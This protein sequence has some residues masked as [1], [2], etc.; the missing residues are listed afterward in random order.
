M[1]AAQNLGE[2]L[3]GITGQITG[4]LASLSTMIGAQGISSAVPTFE[5]RPDMFKNWI[6]N[7]E[8]YAILTNADDNQHKLIAYQSSAGTVSDF[9]Q[10][11]M[12]DHAQATWGDLKTDLAQRFAEV[13]D[14]QHA[15]M[16][17]QKLKQNPGESVQI[18]A[19]RLLN[20]AED[21]YVG[22]GVNRNFPA[23]ERQ[24]VGFFID[25]LAY[26]YLK[27]RIMRENPQTL[28]N[29]VTSATNEQNLRARFDL[30]MG[31]Q[32]SYRRREQNTRV[33]REFVS[34]NREKWSNDS[35]WEEDMDVSH[36]RPKRCYKCNR[37]G[38]QAR[39]C[40]IINAVAHMQTDRQT[41]PRQVICW[42]CN[43]SGHIKRECPKRCRPRFDSP[44]PQR[45]VTLSRS[46][47]ENSLN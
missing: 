8:K 28:A 10:R 40:K 33:R 19:E 5:G 17:L 23:V 36:V 2:Y 39:Q 18:F 3:Q 44:K 42:Y 9:I 25:G 21:A 27:K 32:N 13:T 37:T 4:Q 35:R 46:H 1:A 38:H 14:S 7:I 11:Y 20:L 43:Q 15:F 45:R 47:H 22:L 16:L 24:L 6:K 29:A 31:S 34:P 30:R 12:R 41:A 26:D